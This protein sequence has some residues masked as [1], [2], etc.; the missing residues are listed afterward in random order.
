MTNVHRGMASVGSALFQMKAIS[1]P[2]LFLVLFLAACAST[3]KVD[4]NSR[5]GT[6][7][8]D[9]AVLEL[10]PPDRSS[11]LTDGTTVAEWFI[12]GSRGG[13]SFGLGTGISTG[14][15]GVYGG[16]TFSSAGGTRILRLTFG[17]DGKLAGFK[18]FTQ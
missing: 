6:F 5:V 14:N 3:P 15:V 9:Q 10:G 11:S 4:W 8:Y 18:R 2:W 13:V 1:F 16:P 17:P 12:A 7:T